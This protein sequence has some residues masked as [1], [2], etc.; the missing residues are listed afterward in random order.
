[1]LE[2]LLVWTMSH[3][4]TPDVLAGPFVSERVFGSYQECAA[5]VAMIGGPFIIDKQWQ[6]RIESEGQIFQGRCVER[7]NYESENS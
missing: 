1:M 4:D 2:I 7:Q 5:L 6:F 3:V